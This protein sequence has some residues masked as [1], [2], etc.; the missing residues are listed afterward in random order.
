MPNKKLAVFL[1]GSWNNINDNTSVWR[2][3]QMVARRDDRDV[4]QLSYYT[5]GVGTARGETIR[6]GA[7]GYGLDE[8]VI[9]AYRWL[10]GNFDQNDEKTPSDEI[11]LFGFSRGAFTARSLSGM[12]ARCGLLRA[13]S[14][15]SVEELYNRYRQD[16]DA[17]S[18]VDLYQ[19][20]REFGADSL[21]DLEHRLLRHSR[22]IPIK[23]IG[24]WDTV[25]ALGVPFG[26]IPGLS[27]RRF[28]FH[29]TDLSTLYEHAYHALAI[30]DHR[31]PFAP[32]LWTRHTPTVPE[33][34]GKRRTRLTKVEQRWFV[35]A[36]SNVGG[37][38]AQDDLPQLPTAW[39]VEKA[40]ALGLTFRETIKVRKAEDW[41]GPINDSFAEFAGGL[42]RLIKL[43][44]RYHRIIAEPAK[45]VADGTV[46]PTAETIDASVFDRWRA[47][48]TYR[49]PSIANWAKRLGK[50]PQNLKGTVD[51][52]TGETIPP[53][54]DK[55]LK[56]KRPKATKRAAKPK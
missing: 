3:S 18:L 43:G 35:G 37:G 27:R 26:N 20:R 44:R 46:K 51:A 17:P 40:S 29:N 6:G 8:D 48:S 21:S 2:L 30:D 33:P 47:D 13:G 52:N 56:D 42:Y 15:V 34:E 24:V 4:R 45:A 19:R 12:I 41:K 50:Q 31:A 55:P 49:P 25:G 38:I 7:L 9:A 22:R 28:G 53:A 10:M 14:P 54:E 5:P 16:A 39:L 36:H 1:D 32:T 11:Y 23:M